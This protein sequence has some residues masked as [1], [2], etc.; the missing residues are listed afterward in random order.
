MYND[1]MNRNQMLGIS[2]T[3][4]SIQD[5]VCLATNCNSVE[6][7]D[8]F[9]TLKTRHICQGTKDIRLISSSIIPT[10]TSMGMINVEVFYCPYCRKLIINKSSMEIF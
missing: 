8:S 6:V 9:E 2:P 4:K 7:V 5:Y 1:M 3:K 10:P